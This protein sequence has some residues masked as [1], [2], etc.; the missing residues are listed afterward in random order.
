MKESNMVD[1]IQTKINSQK[2]LTYKYKVTFSENGDLNLFAIDSS[3]NDEAKIIFAPKTKLII[4]FFNKEENYKFSL[5]DTY[6]GE[7]ELFNDL[8]L[9]NVLKIFFAYGSVLVKEI[10]KGFFDK[11]KTY[12]VKVFDGNFGYLFFDE[13]EKEYYT[14]SISTGTQIKGQKCLFTKDEIDRMRPR[15]DI[16]VNWTKAELIES[17]GNDD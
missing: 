13:N 9:N 11:E 14:G 5:E 10:K 12:L 7:T 17:S 1:L 15:K 2:N 16:A 3:N 6:A 4:A 8:I